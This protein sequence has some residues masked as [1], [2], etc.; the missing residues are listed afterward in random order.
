MDVLPPDEESA[1]LRFNRFNI[2]RLLENSQRWWSGVLLSGHL[3]IPGNLAFQWYRCSHCP[4][5][6]VLLPYR[7]QRVFKLAHADKTA[8]C[9]IV[10]SLHL[11]LELDTCALE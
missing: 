2:V 5:N 6:S 9:R 8:G 4:H 3:V 7:P 11:A 1:V 10:A